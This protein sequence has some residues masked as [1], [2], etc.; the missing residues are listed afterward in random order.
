MT[1]IVV[2]GVLALLVFFALFSIREH[3]T[4]RAL[5]RLRGAQDISS[6]AAMFSTDAERTIA[7]VLYPRLEQ[8]ASTREF[9]L[10]KEDRLFSPQF[11]GSILSES[12]TGYCLRL[13]EEDLFDLAIAALTEVGCNAP[14]IVVADELQGVESVGQLVTALGR[15]TSQPTAR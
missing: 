8:Q 3:K 15:L 7:K 9:P 13:L 6:F 2:C 1:I 4:E 11:G 10:A 14:E 5:A 12:A